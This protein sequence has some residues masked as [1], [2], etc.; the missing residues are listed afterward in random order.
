M[1]WFTRGWYDGDLSEEE[2]EGVRAA[3][4]LHLEELAPRLREGAEV[5]VASVNLH[6][7]QVRD[8]T[9]PSEG[10]IELRVLIGDRQVGYEFLTLRY[11]D[12]EL[13]RAPKSDF[14]VL[15]L[16][17]QG[18]ELLYDEVD[19]ADDGRFE[20]RVLCWPDAEFGV[21]FRAVDVSRRPASPADRR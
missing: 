2:E 18:A 17:R 9:V 20:H 16:M 12:A 11:L 4:S 6:D 15:E 3:Y 5:L 10:A 21:R 19:I 7:G 1:K 8:W 14:S 13:I